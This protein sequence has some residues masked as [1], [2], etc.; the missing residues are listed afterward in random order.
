MKNKAKKYLLMMISILIFTSTG[1]N[2]ESQKTPDLP[3]TENTI[4][5]Y[6]E[7]PGDEGVFS[8][9][10]HIAAL[11]QDILDQ[12][13]EAGAMGNL[14]TMHRIIKRLGENGY[15][16]VDEK[17][18]VNMEGLEQVMQFCRSVEEKEQAELT[19]I[20]VAWS[21]GF[22]KYDLKT[23]D[24]RVDVIRG[25]YQNI[26]GELKNMSTVSYPAEE[27]Q[28]TK[29][30][31]LL[32]E[33]S[34][35]SE[36]YYTLSL[37]DMTE[38]VALRVEPLDEKC[39]ELNR[40]YI[41]PIGYSNNNMFLTKWSEEE[42]GELDFYDLFDKFY[43][44]VYEEAIPYT[45]AENAGIGTIYRVPADIFEG[46]VREFIAIDAQKL[47]QR[48][49]YYPEDLSYEYKPRGF[50]ENGYSDTPY[51]E[52]TDY[53]E[54]GDGTLTLTVN[55]VFPEENTSRAFTHEVVVRPLY[56][57]RFQYVSNQPV[58]LEDVGEY[59]AWWYSERLTQEQ[60]KEIYGGQEKGLSLYFSQEAESLISENEKAELKNMALKAAE[61]VKEV[62]KD[63]ET[64]EGPDAGKVRDFSREQ[65]MKAVALLGEAGYTSVADH[66]N[67][68]NYDA[69]EEFYSAYLEERNA[70]V[71][72]F[73]ITSDGLIRVYTFIY[74]EDRLQAYYVE[75]G[76]RE[77]GTPEITST[78]VSDIAEIKLTEKGYFIYAYKALVHH[79]SLRQYWRIKPLS[80][81]CRKLTRKYIS[82]LSYM[83][84][85]MLVT[86]WSSGNAE[87]ILMPCMF[88][89]IYRIDTGEG[90]HVENDEIPAEVYERIMTTYFPVTREQV[91][92]KCGYDAE[93]DSYPYEM[94][95]SS[96]CP[97]FG[98]VVDYTENPDGTLTLF[99]DGVWPD[100]NTDC[101]FKNE[102]VVECFED[103]SFRYLANFIHAI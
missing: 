28:Y 57:G 16:A 93:K 77:G 52:V 70:M 47:Q 81:E 65:Q 38:H 88:E 54:N 21:G 36:S 15:I 37:S 3:K 74:R 49:V 32:F 33:G 87:D 53:T 4:E 59:D 9:A 2:N 42:F 50:Y 48:T 63:A 44:I 97:P 103:G 62:Y 31:Y 25:Y 45:A 8:E 68:E 58:L 26:N 83:N 34:Y 20:A 6:P 7:Y 60:W 69:V 22:T 61:E 82:G 12:A 67:M 99:V 94:I 92:A 29:E 75:V 39:R 51:P 78:L 80:E 18:Q 85:N 79:S 41:M 56:N 101:A 30:G 90:L 24:G 72:I 43:P 14:E 86:N 95:V 23:T 35:Y 19:V 40:Q 71:T 27:W 98:E 84:Y 100:Y 55:A 5:Q 76:W 96:P 64:S 102:I 66:I 10:D 1:C 11:Y 17:N 89:D 91:R 46:A 13:A 73:H